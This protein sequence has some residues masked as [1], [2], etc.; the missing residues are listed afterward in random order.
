VCEGRGRKEHGKDMNKIVVGAPQSVGMPRGRGNKKWAE[1]VRDCVCG[2]V[3]C[4]RR[5][6]RILWG[7][8]ASGSGCWGR[9]L[10]ANAGAT[11][12]GRC[13]VAWA[14]AIVATVEG[15]THP[16][17]KTR[18]GVAVST[19]NSRTVIPPHTDGKISYKKKEKGSCGPSRIGHNTTQGTN[20]WGRTLGWRG[21]CHRYSFWRAG[22]PCNS[23]LRG[24][25][26]GGIGGR[27]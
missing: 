13:R 26:G 9:G 19:L 11:K 14:L 24:C 27:I 17:P 18:R 6:R 16:G 12:K 10:G 7:I 23:G 25:A 1:R 20:G 21:Q 2:R 22:A 8:R 4:T 15:G 5:R 3:R